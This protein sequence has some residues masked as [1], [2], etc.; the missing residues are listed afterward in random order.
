LS[1]TH[2]FKTFGSKPLL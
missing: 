2:I 1:E